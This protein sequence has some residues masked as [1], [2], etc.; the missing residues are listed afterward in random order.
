MV[1]YLKS[2]KVL[3]KPFLSSG[4][5]YVCS[6]VYVNKYLAMQIITGHVIGLLNY[7]Q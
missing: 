5:M 1:N 3:D 6:Y 7:M 2:K 4:K